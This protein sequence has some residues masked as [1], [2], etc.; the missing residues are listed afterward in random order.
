VAP[1]LLCPECGT[2]HPLDHV[3]ANAAFPCTGCGRT[4]KVPEQARQMSA[5]GGS[6]DAA[7]APP[8]PAPPVP[9]PHVTQVMPAVPPEPLAAAAAAPLRPPPETPAPEP[10][11]ERRPAPAAPAAPVPPAWARLL[12]W[13]VAVPIA[14]LLVFGIARAGGFLTTSDITDVALAEGWRRF[15]P[16]V[17]LLPFVAIV[18]ALIV[19]GGVYG[20]ARM[21]AQS[22]T[23]PASGSR[24]KSP[25]RQ[26]S[27]AGA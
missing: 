21:R 23:K 27:R 19:T 25:P 14:F 26:S 6:A 24:P 16:I 17:R 1:V 18:T 13:L 12:L 4:L 10:V 11:R 22:R 5:A 3:A 20:L 15:M 2:K 9:E 7:P 8:P